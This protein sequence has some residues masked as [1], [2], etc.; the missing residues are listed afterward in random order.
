MT[1]DCND[2]LR[3]WNFDAQVG[4]MND[5]FKLVEKSSS[6]D[7]VVWVIHF[8]HIRGQ[9]LCFGI[10]NKDTGLNYMYHSRA[11]KRIPL[12]QIFP[13]MYHSRAQK[14]IPLRCH[15]VCSDDERLY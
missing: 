2:P 12:L 8:H 11:Q 13:S 3:R 1:P 10:L 14:R 4:L 6:E 9:V 7:S 15:F 5:S